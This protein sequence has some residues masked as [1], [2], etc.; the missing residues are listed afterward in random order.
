MDKV[1]HHKKACLGI[2]H[3]VLTIF[4]NLTYVP[5]WAISTHTNIDRGYYEIEIATVNEEDSTV[6]IQKSKQFTIYF[7]V[8]QYTIQPHFA[9]NASALE[10]LGIFIKRCMQDSALTI[11]SIDVSSSCSV[12]G[13]ASFN[14]KLSQERLQCLL[15][16]MI[17]QYPSL[18][19]YPIKTSS[20]GAHWSELADLIQQSGWKDRHEIL[21]LVFH[22]TDDEQRLQELQTMDNCIPYPHILVYIYPKIRIGNIRLD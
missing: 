12:E 13:N 14:Q 22:N 9:D 4:L 7:P 19:N 3:L 8:S 18:K 5:T 16:Y 21:Q 17:T 15:K 10:K 20:R 1:L 11:E 2:E 6:N